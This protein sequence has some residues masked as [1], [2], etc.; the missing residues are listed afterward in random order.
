MTYPSLE[1]EREEEEVKGILTTLP[2]PFGVPQC[3]VNDVQVNPDSVRAE[4][5]E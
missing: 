1:Y 4:E 5:S 2:S 3:W